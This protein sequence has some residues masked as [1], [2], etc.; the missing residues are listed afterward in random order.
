[1]RVLLSKPFNLIAFNLMWLGCVLGRN[2]W[3]LLLAPVVFGYATLLLLTRTIQPHQLLIPVS[4]GLS[5]DAL[6]TITRLFQFADAP[7]LLPAWLVVLWV[8][9]STT[10]T[11]SLEVVGRNKWLASLAGAIAIPFNYAVGERLGAVSFG[12]TPLV[13]LVALGVTWMLLLPVLF[14]L[15]ERKWEKLVEGF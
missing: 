4:A 10:L 3:I 13:T 14:Y 2:D 5:V 15:C 12:D 11:L 1:M 8:A 6:M 7:L 9:F